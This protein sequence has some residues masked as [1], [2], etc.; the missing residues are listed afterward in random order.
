MVAAI[1]GRRLAQAR[2]AGSQVIVSACQQCERTL[3]AAARREHTLAA[4][5]RREHTLA[6]A[7]RRERIRLR[8][9]DIVEIVRDAL[10]A[11]GTGSD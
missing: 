2:Q 3:A 1:S 8:V 11:H 10:D 4:A 9:L 5:A 7:A 6:A